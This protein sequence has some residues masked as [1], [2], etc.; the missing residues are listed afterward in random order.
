MVMLTPATSF[1]STNGPPSNADVPQS[2]VPSWLRQ[3]KEDRTSKARDLSP[4]RGTPAQRRSSVLNS[5]S[6]LY[7][8]PSVADTVFMTESE[9]FHDHSVAPIESHVASAA[10]QG[11]DAAFHGLI[12]SQSDSRLT[13]LRSSRRRRSLS[14]PLSMFKPLT[15]HVVQLHVEPFAAEASLFQQRLS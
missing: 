3:V 9:V 8:E 4:V 5:F 6:V 1:A 15:D 13:D 10:E 2:I 11:N 7:H 14:V 12:H